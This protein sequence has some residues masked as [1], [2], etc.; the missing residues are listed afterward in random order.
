[1]EY[2]QLIF[3]YLDSFSY[4]ALFVLAFFSGIVVPVPEE[5]II[6]AAG[7]FVSRGFMNLPISWFIIILAIFIS[8][9]LIFRLCRTDNHLINKFRNRVLAMKIMKHRDYMEKHIDKTIFLS[10]FIPFMRFVGPI[11]A[12]TIKTPKKD[13][14]IFNTLAI[15]VYTTLILSVGYFFSDQM[16]YIAHS[17]KEF[18]DAMFWLLVFIFGFLIINHINNKLDV[19][20]KSCQTDNNLIK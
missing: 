9:N 17:I 19:S 14:F 18:D 2:L 10:R 3:G 6:I 1:M 16:N 5:I 15:V 11:L 4:L 7:W 13:F 12:A 8:D 20:A